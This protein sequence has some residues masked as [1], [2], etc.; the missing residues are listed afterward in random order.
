MASF[1]SES[2]VRDYLQVSGTSG[3]WS[4]GLIGSNIRAASN[5]LQRWTNRQFE[6]QAATTKTFSTL[7]RQYLVLPGLR[8]ATSVTLNSSALTADES[9]Y[10]QADRLQTGVYVGIEFP[11]RASFLHSSDWF[12]RGYDS[13]LWRSRLVT[14]LPNDLVI[15][16]DWGHSPIPDEVL[17]ATK[18]LAAYYTIRPDALLSGARQ[19]PEGNVFDLSRLPVEIQGF[20]N[21]WKLE[22]RVVVL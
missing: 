20:I 18:V 11:N 14:G 22:D 6:A 21:D 4:S 17:H 2:D 8:T 9:Y 3:Q 19:T 7:G 10:L 1:V 16:G 13:P 15:V 5:N 12:D